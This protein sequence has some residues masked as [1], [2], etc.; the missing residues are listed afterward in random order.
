MR[1]SIKHSCTASSHAAQVVRAEL[2]G[3]TVCR[4][5][6]VTVCSHTPILELCRGLIRAGI[7]P[8]RGLHCHRDGVLCVTVRSIGE[9]A[10]LELNSKGTGFVKRHTAVRTVPSV[11]W[12]GAPASHLAGGAS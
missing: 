2:V 4:A 10:A 1:G 6:G 7:N 9:A 5:E 8:A 11:R 12:R 3:D